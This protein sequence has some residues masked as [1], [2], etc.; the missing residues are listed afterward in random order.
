MPVIAPDLPFFLYHGTPKNI[1]YYE[2]DKKIVSQI[3]EI[4]IKVQKFKISKT[5]KIYRKY[6]N[7]SEYKKIADKLNDL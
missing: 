1:I 3:N 6:C 7:Q 5:S 2:Y 4:F